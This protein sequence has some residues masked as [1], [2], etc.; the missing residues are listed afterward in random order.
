MILLLDADVYAYRAMKLSQAD[1][2]PFGFEGTVGDVDEAFGRYRTSVAEDLL[3]FPLDYDR[4]IH[5]FSGGDNWRKRENPDYKANRKGGKPDGYAALLGMVRDRY[6]CHDMFGM[7]GDDLMG[8]LATSDYDQEKPGY[9]IVSIDKD[10]LTL[11]C[12]SWDPDKKGPVR[13]PS[14]E[15]ADRFFWTQVLTGDPVDGYKGAQGIGKVK[16]GRIMDSVNPSDYQQVW[17]MIVEVYESRGQTE[18]DARMNARMAR[19]CRY[20]EWDVKERTLAWQPPVASEKPR[21]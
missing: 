9:C 20:G 13:Q 15:E 14:V 21:T 7:E 3:D 8:L 16:A 12:L 1:L 11:P 18:E 17:D 4:V 2:G 10:M 6:T 19:I 5:V